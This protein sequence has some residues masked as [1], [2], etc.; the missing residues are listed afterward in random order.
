MN[1]INISRSEGTGLGLKKSRLSVCTVLDPLGYY[2]PKQYIFWPQTYLS[3]EYL[4]AELPTSWVHGP[5]GDVK[6]PWS[7]VSDGL[8][9]KGLLHHGKMAVSPLTVPAMQ[10]S[11]PF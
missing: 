2:V 9:G 5:L 1:K 3:W 6:T 4:K 7:G 8:T 11:S 10:S